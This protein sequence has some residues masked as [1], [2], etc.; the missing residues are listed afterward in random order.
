MQIIRAFSYRNYRLY[1]IGQSLSLV[2][3]WMQRVAVSWLVYRLTSSAF[4]LGV[5]GFTGQIP[6]LFLASVAG[7]I[8]D[9]SDRHRMLIVTQVLAMLQAGIFAFLILHERIAIWQIIALSVFLGIINAFDMPTR[10]SM[11]VDLID[12][13][14]DLGNAIALNSSMV[15][16]ARLIGPSLAGLLI[17]AV[18]EGFCFLINAVSYVAVIGALWAMH[19]PSRPIRARGS[20]VLRELRDGVAYVAASPP[21][22]SVLW[23]LGL[24][25]IMGMPYST[26]MPIF[27]QDILHGGPQTLGFLMSA[28]G[29]GALGGAMYLAS[30]PNA[31]GLERRIPVA[32]ALFGMGLIAL[33][34]SRVL[35]IALILMV[36][37]GFGMMLQMAASNTVLQTLV[38]DEMRGRVMSLYTMALMGMVPFGNLLAGSLA[39]RV[40]APRTLL[41]GGTACVA[42]AS[43]FARGL[44]AFRT[45]ANPALAERQPK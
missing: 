30:R 22:R 3:T 6:A 11:V 24:V 21:I 7:V 42:G 32:A 26:L 25:G 41:I 35:W 29:I 17:A 15:N 33:S 1:F 23:L 38:A 5:V 37:T 40:G 13:R 16:G 36:M 27:A 19:I 4:L 28:S 10:Q 8:I 20:K 44:T 14:E 39:A 43:L 31:I 12:K 18:G 2:G 34:F 9:R 45:L